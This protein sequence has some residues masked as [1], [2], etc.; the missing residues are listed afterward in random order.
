M[1]REAV[2]YMKY[3]LLVGIRPPWA[4]ETFS[5]ALLR[6]GLLSQFMKPSHLQWKQE[7]AAVILGKKVMAMLCRPASNAKLRV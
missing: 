5:S 7:D 1:F 4:H 6:D 3:N 2:E